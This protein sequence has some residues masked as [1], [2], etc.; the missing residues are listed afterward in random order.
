MKIIQKLPRHESNA[1]QICDGC[2][3]AV[4]NHNISF[5]TNDKPDTMVKLHS[6]LICK[7]RKCK[8]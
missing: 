2:G 6:C 3:H 4:S 5:N 1:Y 8:W 7:S